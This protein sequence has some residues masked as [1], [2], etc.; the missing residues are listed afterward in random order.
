MKKPRYFFAQNLERGQWPE[1]RKLVIISEAGI[2]DCK[3]YSKHMFSVTDIKKF[4]HLNK[5][6]KCWPR[7]GHSRGNMQRR[8]SCH[9]SCSIHAYVVK[10]EIK[11][12]SAQPTELDWAGLNLAT[13][14][15]KWMGFDPSERSIVF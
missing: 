2:S 3:M 13:T 5:G 15:N 12:I 4:V 6:K 9:N 7:Y 11:D 8:R 10:V 14:E 1:L